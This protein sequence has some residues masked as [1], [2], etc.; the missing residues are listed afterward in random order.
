MAITLGRFHT[1]SALHG[2]TT[3]A[4]EFNFSLDIRAYEQ[5]LLDHME[6]RLAEIIE[7]IEK[8]RGVR[9]E[10]GPRR[11]AGIGHVDPGMCEALE[12]C[13]NELGIDHTRMYSPAS[14][15]AAA[16]AM[17]GIPTGMIMI[18]NDHGSH[19]PAESM[20]ID[21]FLDALKILVAWL[22]QQADQK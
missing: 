14:H 20:S 7:R 9:F 11:S 8:E 16:F 15:D 18:R 22:I 13:A 3:I 21:D 10:L 4:G 19:N 17:A 6:K 2:L 5:D 12:Q 1:D